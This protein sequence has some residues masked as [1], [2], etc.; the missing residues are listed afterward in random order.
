MLYHVTTRIS[1][2]K[3]IVF[4]LLFNSVF[5]TLCLS[6]THLLSN[7]HKEQMKAFLVVAQSYDLR[8][9]LKTVLC[10]S[11]E[12]GKFHAVFW[13]NIF[14]PWMFFVDYH[15]VFM[16][17]AVLKLTA[18]VLQFLHWVTFKDILMAVKHFG[19]L[20]GKNKIESA[21]STWI[22]S[23]GRWVKNKWWLLAEDPK[24]Q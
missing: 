20:K 4:D 22:V 19:T 6:Q 2:R 17:F 11:K 15:L 21:Y 9:W 8:W 24:A 7:S 16:A 12:S 5:Q 10:F 23:T 1:K 3:W 18:A 14:L 13:T